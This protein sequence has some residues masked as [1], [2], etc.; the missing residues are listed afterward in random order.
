MSKA[1]KIRGL[2]KMSKRRGIF[3]LFWALFFLALFWYDARYG[4]LDSFSIL[5]EPHQV[6]VRAPGKDP[7]F[8]KRLGE[9]GNSTAE[10]RKSASAKPAGAVR[11]CSFNVKNY[12]VSNRHVGGVWRS[13]YP[14]PASEKRAIRKILLD[15]DADVLLLQEM[16]SYEYMEELLD[17]LSKEGLDYSYYT[18]S[19]GAD[20]SRHLGIASKIKIAEV[21]A[22]G[23]MDFAV[24]SELKSS[25]RGVLLVG[26]ARPDAPGEFWFAGTLHLKSKFG[27]KKADGLFNAY[28]SAELSRLLKYV[29]AKV[30]GRPAVVA[31]DFNDEPFEK[32]ISDVLRESEFSYIVQGDSRGRPYS[33]FWKR[34]SVN[35]VY[36]FFIA[37]SSAK[38]W[39]SAPIVYGIDLSASDHSAVY[40]DLKFPSAEVLRSN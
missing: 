20:N 37:N 14:K 23:G 3:A 1:R 8:A 13:E 16:G 6:R 26:F 31:G 27:A 4:I 19:S 22:S 36:D 40:T 12:F 33:Y 5:E 2:V 10:R 17:A 34:K 32:H 9:A 28:R 11:V 21:Y 25:P 38:A 35:Y 39:A 24:G 29:R 15:I 18:L 7:A 30:S